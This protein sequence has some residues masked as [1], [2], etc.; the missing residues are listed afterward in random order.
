MGTPL[1]HTHQVSAG[2]F[3]R[4]FRGLMC[5]AIYTA[6]AVAAVASP[7]PA[8]A[9]VDQTWNAGGIVFYTDAVD[10]AEDLIGLASIAAV[11]EFLRTAAGRRILSS[12]VGTLSRIPALVRARIAVDKS[13][14]EGHVSIGQLFASLGVL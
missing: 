6:A 1:S 4:I 12:A 13:R 2:S 3:E 8:E 5:A 10:N 9:P 7:V 14:F 11:R